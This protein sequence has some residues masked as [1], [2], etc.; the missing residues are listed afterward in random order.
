[1][2]WYYYYSYCF[3]SFNYY[4]ITTRSLGN[5]FPNELPKLYGGDIITPKQFIKYIQKLDKRG[6][7]ICDGGTV[8]MGQDW[9]YVIL[10]MIFLVSG[11]LFGGKVLKLYQIV[12]EKF[13]K[14]ETD[15]S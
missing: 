1:M 5:C 8:E 15:I 2:G 11:T 13:W 12:K 10:M 7:A 3:N 4:I 6:L 14:M 9:L